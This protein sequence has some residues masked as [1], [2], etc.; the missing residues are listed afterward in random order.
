[1]P[2]EKVDAMTQMIRKQIYIGKSQQALLARLAKAWGVSEAEVIRQ[3]IERE[4]TSG[5]SQ[6]LQPDATALEELIQ[7]ALQRRTAGITGDPLRWRRAIPM[8]SA[9]IVAGVR[10]EL[11][12]CCR[13]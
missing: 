4:A 5:L 7:A 9:W 10:M 12:P 2:F 6:R 1:M 13:S 8:L 11:S 3:A